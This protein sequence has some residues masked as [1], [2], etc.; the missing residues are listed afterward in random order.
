MPLSSYHKLGFSCFVVCC[1]ILTAVLFSIQVW[2][3]IVNLF[4][5]IWNHSNWMCKTNHIHYWY[6]V[7][8]NRFLLLVPWLFKSW[9]HLESCTYSW[10]FHAITW[11]HCGRWS[12]WHF[13]AEQKHSWKLFEHKY[14]QLNLWTH[15]QYHTVSFFTTIL[16]KINFYV[17]NLQG[18]WALW[19]VLPSREIWKSAY[20]F[21]NISNPFICNLTCA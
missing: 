3:I 9:P 17:C 4:L 19:H 13:N 11:F 2:W 8:V 20:L 18:V 14:C 10:V 6:F 12:Y 1:E 7:Q 21:S 16:S 5:W 15:R